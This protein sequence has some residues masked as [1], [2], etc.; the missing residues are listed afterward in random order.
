MNISLNINQTR[1]HS[2]SFNFAYSTG[3]PYTAPEGFVRYQGR[4]YPY[5]DERNQYRLPAYHRLDFAWNIYN[6]SLKARRW[7]GH[8]TFTV[9]N[10]YG[11]KNAYSIFYRTGEQ[12]NRLAIFAAPIPS[13]TYNFEFK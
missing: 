4:T 5:Y 2:F 8:W 3:R 6:A 9:Y 10:L 7:Q 12:A 11:R 13:L 1:H